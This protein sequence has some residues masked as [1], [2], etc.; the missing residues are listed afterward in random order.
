[1]GRQRYARLVPWLLVSCGLAGCLE[2]RKELHYLGDA[3]LS[4][5]K[6]SATEIDYTVVDD[7]GAAVVANT[8]QPH[9]LY[10]RQRDEVWDM[11]LVEAIQLAMTNNKI[12]R[13]D[14]QF[15]NSGS[16]LVRSPDFA[17]S[18][19][20]P[21][22]Q[23]SGVLFGN[24]GV[25]AALADFDTNFT[26]SLVW[27]RDERVQNNAFF[28]GGLDAGNTLVNETANFSAALEKQF[29][30]GGAFGVTHDWDY[31]GT[32]APGT[33]FPTSYTGN[34]GARYRQPL[35]AGAG[36]E[37]TRIAGPLNPNFGGI[38][39]V[40]QGVVIARINNDIELADFE[41]NVRNMLIDVE[42]LYWDL[43]L[44]YRLYDTVVVAHNSALRTWREA[45]AK[46]DIGGVRNFK[47]ADEAQASDQLF[48]TRAGVE[49]VL[50][51]LY[52]TESSLRR[53]LGLPVND[54]R[55]I[56]PFDEPAA[57][58]FVPDWNSSLA[59]ALAGRV[60][61][62]K[63]KW[64]IKSLELQLQAARSLTNPRLD[65]V[66]AYRV[67]GFGDTL[68]EHG[69]NDGVTAQGLNSAYETLSQGN[70][71]GWN[72]GFEFAMPI[73]FRSAHAQVRNYELRLAKARE[74]LAVQEMDIAHELAIAV[75][76]LERNYQTAQT[77]WNRR[78]AAQRRVEL[79]EAEVEAGTATLDLVLRAQTSL[80]DADRDYYTSLTNYNKSI[81][82]LHF[83]KGT[84][85]EY[86]NVF[87]AETEWSPE[88]YREAL[89]RAWARSHAFDAEHL[90]TEPAEF[91][92]PE[93][94]TLLEQPGQA[95]LDPGTIPPAPAE[96]PMQELPNRF[97]GTPN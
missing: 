79:F 96:D 61:L 43:Y 7:P 35:W 63:Q 97:D 44:Q 28:G 13:T 41:A 47:P 84:L 72:L 20:D 66:S 53:M 15:L 76:N 40:S 38:T 68:L 64:A 45:K 5:Y 25:E 80:A 88:A 17:P 92:W 11:T 24:R 10:N 75:Q 18:S 87:L 70:Q 65:F 32:N 89:R 95:N 23:E 51:Q 4:H 69:D 83:R 52:T 34:L 29:A 71:T 26:T 78:I 90:D 73:G 3:E 58:Q 94:R 9:T 31:L 42:N 54:G 81:A 55:V 91:A 74:L 12:I 50:S 93:G 2:S 36:V 21:A 49:N 19:L 56:R 46:L 1:M 14:Q 60:E 59:E 30:Y 37:Y 6:Q 77:N 39:G 67:N 33:L 8:N 85:L 57:G 62:R 22:I 16:S 27:G 86:D 82:N 48:A